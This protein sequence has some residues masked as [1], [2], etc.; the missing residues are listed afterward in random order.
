FHYLFFLSSLFDF[1]FIFPVR[2]R[3]KFDKLNFKSF[4]IAYSVVHVAVL[5]HFKSSLEALHA[6]D[7]M[8]MR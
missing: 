2:I 4:K 6:R 5:K 7:T 3:Q 1:F 8:E